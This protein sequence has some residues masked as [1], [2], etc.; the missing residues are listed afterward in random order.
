MTYILRPLAGI[1]VAAIALLA[2]G[3][4]LDVRDFDQTNGGY[5][6]PYEGVTGTLVDW[7]AMDRTSTGLAKRGH[8]VNVLVDGTTGMISFEIFKHK[9][10]FRPFSER[11]LVVHKPREAFIALGFDPQF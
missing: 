1:G 3:L 4:Y 11:A 6:A 2:I 5:E 7:Y 10:D 8:V 9:I